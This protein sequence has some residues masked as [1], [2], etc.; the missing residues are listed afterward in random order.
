MGS[1]FMPATQCVR[2]T[3]VLL[4]AHGLAAIAPLV[5]EA[6]IPPTD[7]SPEVKVIDMHTHI[8]NA[9]DLPLRGIL[10]ARGAPVPV[11]VI[12]A[13][14]LLGSMKDQ[15]TPRYDLS[16]EEMV[17]P[18][19]GKLSESDR[20]ILLEYVGADLTELHEPAKALGF[21]E[22][23]T[24]VAMAMAK[25]GF[26]P[27]DHV[28][29]D[30]Y[31]SQLFASR[32]VKKLKIPISIL[33][34]YGR[35]IGIMLRPHVEI[36]AALQKSY[37]QVDL[38]VHHMM[39]M[40]LAYDDNPKVPFAQQIED[41][42]KVD[43]AFPGKLLHFVAFDPFRR[44]NARPLVEG[45]VHGFGAVGLKIYPPSGYRAAENVSG[46]FPPKP[47][48]DAGA[49]NRW[50]SRYAGWREQDLDDTLQGAFGWSVEMKELPLFTHCTPG[51]FEAERGYGKMANPSFWAA[52]LAKKENAGM[53]LCFGHG[54][55]DAYWFSDPADD[56]KHK[57]D[58]A[59]QFGDKVVQLCL[60]YPNVYCD[61]GYF[62]GILNPKKARALLARVQSVIDLPSEDGGAWKFGDKMMYG[63]D[64]HMIIKEPHHEKYLACW[65]DLMKHVKGGSW[66]QAFFAGNAK[67]FL[68][69]NELANDKRFAA[70]QHELQALSDGI[71]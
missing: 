61:V 29:P 44:Q 49:V 32:K 57:G 58:A 9:R 7:G 70:E 1:D 71:K 33:G 53:R 39:D 30:D 6:A 38:F 37:P 56:A 23:G 27:D 34:G 43:A 52:V 8:F 2:R 5:I 11:A 69:L 21:S 25:I 26:P 60:K 63:S 22:D 55:G 14:I 48:R 68:R 10:E 20:E 50:K 35:F 18:D 16:I 24:L 54:G 17:R 41:M 13:T 65:D 47:S 3:R 15:G 66:R 46:K 51:G 62:S 67:K 28:T 40:A 31:R 4:L 59:W 45:A 42:Q 12:L 19:V 36:A 64:W